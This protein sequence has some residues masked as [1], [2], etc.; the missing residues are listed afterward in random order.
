MGEEVEKLK[1]FAHDAPFGKGKKT[2][3]DTKYREAMQITVRLSFFICYHSDLQPE[4]YEISPDPI[5]TTDILDQIAKTLHMPC[6]LR[7]ERAKL[8]IYSPGG[9]FDWH[10][11]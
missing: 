3:Y 7:A 4:R 8:N 2:V 9:F 1:K 6:K 10:V 5:F 11:E